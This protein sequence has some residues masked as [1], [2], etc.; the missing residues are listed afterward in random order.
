MNVWKRASPVATVA[1]LLG[2][3]G[4]VAGCGGVASIADSGGPSVT[5]AM[6]AEVFADPAIVFTP[7]AVTIVAGGTV[8]FDF[9][10]VAH[11]V[12]F[13]NQPTGAP[14][15]ISGNNANTSKTLTFTTPGTFVYNCHIHPGMHGTVV[16][17]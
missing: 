15:S 10:P 8:V 7:A 16:V 17:K 2:F 12:F 6:S 5:P 11:N 3:S 1:Q 4:A 13:D 9:G 14:P